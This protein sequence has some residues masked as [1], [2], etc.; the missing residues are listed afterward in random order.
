MRLARLIGPELATLLR[1]SPD[2]L[3]DLLEEVHPED[4]AD[5]VSE[6]DDEQATALLSRLPTDIACL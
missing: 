2:E 4:I 5:I 3:G 1:E 6:F